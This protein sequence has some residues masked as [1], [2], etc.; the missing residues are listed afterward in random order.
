MM[1]EPTKPIPPVTR[2]LEID[3]AP[4]HGKDGIEKRTR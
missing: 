1:A 2:A 4:A 3:M